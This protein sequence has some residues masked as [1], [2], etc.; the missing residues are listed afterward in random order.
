MMW[1][2][3]PQDCCYS[4]PARASGLFLSRLIPPQETPSAAGVIPGFDWTPLMA[5]ASQGK[6]AMVGELL[7]SGQ[8]GDK[9]AR[10]ARP[11]A[12]NDPGAVYGI[13]NCHSHALVRLQ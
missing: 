8:G 9:E 4:A 3:D 2:D 12:P 13:C 1:W 6:A 5:A 10:Y 11:R 7:K